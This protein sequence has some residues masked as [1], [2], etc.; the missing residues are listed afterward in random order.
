MM[1]VSSTSFLWAQFDER[2]LSICQRKT[3]TIEAPSG[4]FQRA[5]GK[6]HE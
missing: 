3:Y 5:Y 6:L 2:K 4:G 1:N